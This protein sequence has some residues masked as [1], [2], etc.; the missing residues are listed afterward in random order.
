MRY[1][2]MHP[3]ELEAAIDDGAPA[4][5]PWGALEWHGPHLPLGL[6]GLV[7]ETFAERLAERVDG[8]LLPTAWW[9]V[10]TLPHRFSLQMSSDVFKKMIAAM[11]HEL[12]RVGVARV[13]LVSG[14]YAQPHEVLLIEA[15]E[16]ALAQ[17]FLV[18]T[19]PPLALLGDPPYLDHAGRWETSQLLA[20]RPDLVRL[21]RLDHVD[22]DDAP[23]A[24][25]QTAVLGEDPRPTAT[26][27]TGE[28]IVTR[29]LDEWTAALES[30]TVE[31]LGDFYVRRRTEYEDWL[32]EYFDGDWEAALQTWWERHLA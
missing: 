20:F 30:L 27:A 8:V 3:A 5:L 22:V 13:A 4:V 21:E 31:W 24:P 26:P 32:A 28:A 19:A 17:D 6:D 2:E 25:E 15:A 11:L 1:V 12:Q 16:A 7:A 14:H 10:T 23:D 29:A 18:L 9:A